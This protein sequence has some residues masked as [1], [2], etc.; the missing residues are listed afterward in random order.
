MQRTTKI[1]VTLSKSKE[2]LLNLNGKQWNFDRNCQISSENCQNFNGNCQILQRITKIYVILSKLKEYLLN[3]NGKQWNFNKNCQ[4]S[5]ENCQNLMA[6]AK[7]NKQ[8]Y[9]IL[10]KLTKICKILMENNEILARTVKF[11]KTKNLK[12]N[13]LLIATIK[14]VFWDILYIM[15]FVKFPFRIG[16]EIKCNFF[17]LSDY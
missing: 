9:V 17:D 2:Y 5:T 4:T 3:L 11:L 15:S 13:K 10:W 1:Y 6:T 7:N 16:C 14:F 12:F 8:I